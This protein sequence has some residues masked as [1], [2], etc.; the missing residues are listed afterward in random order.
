MKNRILKY[1]A[2]LLKKRYNKINIQM[3]K[4]SKGEIKVR[5][6]KR[7]AGRR[8][9]AALLAT[10]LFST[11]IQLPAAAQTPKGPDG[12]TENPMV[13]LDF[14]SV[15]GTALNG[16]K[17]T[18]SYG[19]EAAAMTDGGY[20]LTDRIT[21]HYLDLTENKYLTVTKADGTPLLTGKD[22][23]TIMYDSYYLGTGQSWAFCADSDANT[24][25][26]DGG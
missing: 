5:E 8:I 11:S 6:R 18:D 7:K 12:T 25:N 10:A 20:T 4:Q 22:A 19:T 9:G 1:V 26:T 14:N 21:D 13:S 3:L 24:P 17:F 2:F 15:T 23:V 16:L